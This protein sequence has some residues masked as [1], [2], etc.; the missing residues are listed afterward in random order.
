VV[1]G[2]QKALRR[3]RLPPRGISRVRARRDVH[4][5]EKPR[6]IPESSLFEASWF[7]EKKTKK[8][9]NKKNKKTKNPKEKGRE[10]K[11]PGKK[12]AKEKEN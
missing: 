10:R 7:L 11:R 4:L 5:I 1:F 9:K 3:R 8:Q 6:K 12:K 2:I